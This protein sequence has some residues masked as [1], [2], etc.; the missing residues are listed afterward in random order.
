MPPNDPPLPS[1]QK[2]EV[3]LLFGRSSTMMNAM[4]GRKTATRTHRRAL[5]PLL[6][7]REPVITRKTA[8]S[9]IPMI[10]KKNITLSSLA[11]HFPTVIA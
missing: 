6:A 2:A 11:G 5:W 9:T 8:H 7:A 10:Q 1:D 4:M 3:L